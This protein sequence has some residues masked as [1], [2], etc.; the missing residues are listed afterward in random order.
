METRKIK[1]EKDIK[2]S[3]MLVQ[4]IMILGVIGLA[5]FI[6]VLVIRN[7]WIAAGR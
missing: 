6:M 2:P 3:P 1:F 7:A 5:V 4:G